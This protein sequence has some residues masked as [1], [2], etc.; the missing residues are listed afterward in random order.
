[1][2]SYVRPKEKRHR[3]KIIPSFYN[4][5]PIKLDILSDV[6]SYVKAGEDFPNTTGFG[7]IKLI[8][9]LNN[10]QVIEKNSFE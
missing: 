1:M 2:N 6:F 5:K 3:S 9:V 8:R 10:T 7:E 4:N